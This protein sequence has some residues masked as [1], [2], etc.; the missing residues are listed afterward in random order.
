MVQI[1]APQL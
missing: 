1:I